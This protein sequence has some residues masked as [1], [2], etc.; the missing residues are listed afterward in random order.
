MS[1][2][3]RHSLELQFWGYET[4]NIVAAIAGAGGL[5]HLIGSLR[6]A[7]D[8]SGGVL[9]ALAVLVT[10]FPEAAAT[11]GVVALVVF[12]FPVA[13]LANRVGGARCADAVHAIAVPLALALLIYAVAATASPFTM[14]ACAFVT[15]S[16]LLR[17]AGTYPLLLKLGGL[18]LTLGGIALAA[19]GATLPMATVP[20]IGLALAT[21]LSG[22]YVAGAGLL[23]WR[24][25]CFVIADLGVQPAATTPLAGL[26]HPTDGPIARPS[27]RCLDPVI[28]RICTGLV[29]PAIF[30]ARPD[31]KAARPFYLSMLARLPW[32]VIAMGFGVAS[33]TEIGLAFALANLLWA[34][35]DIAIGALD[36]PNRQS[37]VSSAT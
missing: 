35:G 29:L 33:G 23:T 3:K 16:C 24:G 13:K 14:A 7:S 28:D 11:L 4:G 30:W 20:E 15:G 32:R 17:S 36:A 9:G 2:L 21:I 27:S 6:A 31:I 37:L 25:G 10:G 1:Y 19:A 8:A 26:L 12:A 34:L 22:A 5:S 18:A